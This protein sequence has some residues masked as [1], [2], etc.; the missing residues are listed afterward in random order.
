MSA[1]RPA[2][3]LSAPPSL[4]SLPFSPPS[5]FQGGRTGREASL[6]LIQKARGSGWI[7]GGA[8][9]TAA[10]GGDFSWRE[11][12]SGSGASWELGVGGRRRRECVLATVFSSLCSVGDGRKCGLVSGPR[13]TRGGLLFYAQEEGSIDGTW[14]CGLDIVRACGTSSDGCCTRRGIERGGRT[15]TAFDSPIIVEM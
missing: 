7:G 9:N 5:L 12:G 2:P 6:T 4:L 13:P 11:M 1:I 10:T 8:T 3:P 14:A 15:I